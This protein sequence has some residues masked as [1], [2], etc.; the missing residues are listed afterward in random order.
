VS[1]PCVLALQDINPRQ[2]PCAIGLRKDSEIVFYDLTLAALIILVLSFGNHIL[3]S[4]RRLIHNTVVLELNFI[5]CR[6]HV[7]ASV[8]LTRLFRTSLVFLNL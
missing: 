6:S 4:G 1:P 2:E 8:S 7:L 5:R 3:V